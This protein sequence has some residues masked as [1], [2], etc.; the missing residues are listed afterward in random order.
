MNNITRTIYGAQLQTCL[1]LGKAVT[2]LENTTL[3]QKFG[4]AANTLPAPTERPSLAYYCWG[5]RGHQS[6]PGVSNIS[7]NV[8]VQHRSTDA[9]L[10]GQ[11]PFVL[12]ETN[13]DLSAVQRS[14]YALRRQETHNG[15]AYFAYYLRRLDLSNVRP[16]MYYSQIDDN[17]DTPDITAFV[18]TEANL[19]PTP[20]A[21]NNVGTSVI[22]A[23]YVSSRARLEVLISEDDAREMLNVAK[24]IYGSEDYAIISELG[25]CTGVDRAITVSGFGGANFNF[26]EAI[27]VQIATHIATL[28]SL[29]NSNRNSSFSVDVGAN[30]P[31]FALSH[32]DGSVVQP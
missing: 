14:N 27:G 23:D 3:N 11:M 12:R 13:N 28:I 32:T 31:L 10:Y 1:Y 9:A 22:S 15:T 29:V 20:P 26:N 18:P 4:I 6:V 21:I 17:S 5:N 16:S 7:L 19:S 8:I 25:L 2:Y 30:E 24:V